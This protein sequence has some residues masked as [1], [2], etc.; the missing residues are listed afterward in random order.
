MQFVIDIPEGVDVI[1]DR[2][3]PNEVISKILWQA[4]KNGTPLPER[5]GRLIDADEL[6]KNNEEYIIQYP[7]DTEEDTRNMMVEWINEDITNAPT[8]IESYPKIECAKS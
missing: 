3:K 6:K 1:V 7:A 8:I 5:H 2:N 4:V